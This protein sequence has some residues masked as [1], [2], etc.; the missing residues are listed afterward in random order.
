MGLMSMR[1]TAVVL[2]GSWRVSDT[3]IARISMPRHNRMNGVRSCQKAEIPAL[4]HICFWQLPLHVTD[5]PARAMICRLARNPAPSLPAGTSLALD[6][7][8]P[9]NLLDV[10][11]TAP[12]LTPAQIM[13]KTLLAE[14]T[15]IEHVLQAYNRGVWNSKELI[16]QLNRIVFPVTVR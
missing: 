15:N 6:S 13:L 8:A 12:K 7:E 1:I 16:D 3:G 9:M 4:G 5:N 11:I 2:L 10:V 14:R